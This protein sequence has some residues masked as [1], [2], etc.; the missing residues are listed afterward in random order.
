MSR[1]STLPPGPL[2][3]G[4]A[5]PRGLPLSFS[6][7]ANPPWLAVRTAYNKSSE[8]PAANAGEGASGPGTV[9]LETKLAL[10]RRTP[11]FS[12]LPEDDLRAL[13]AGCRE[14][15]L[16]H[17]DVV[18][19]EGERGSS[20]YVV[21]SGQVVVS[22]QGKRIALGGPGDCFG[23]MALIEGK[24]RSAG[25]SALSEAVVLEIPEDQFHERIA[26]NPQALLALLRTLS[27][28]SRRDLD[29]L[30]R[31]N[32]KLQEYAAEVEKANRE[33]TKIRQQLEEKNR[34]LERLSTLDTLT[35][36]AN[37]R[38]FDEVLRQEWK[39]AARDAAPL[40][41][42]YCDID[43]FKGYNDSY[44]HRAGDEC[45]QRVARVLADAAHRPADL[46]ARYGGEEFVVLLVDTAAEGALILAERMRVSVEQLRIAH[47]SSSI[48]AFLTA[49]FGVAALVPQAAVN[50]EELI[51]R[52]DRALYAAKQ[53][54]R[55]LVVAAPPA[56]AAPGA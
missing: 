20:M 42:I 35:G 21:L 45:L 41:L 43:F 8:S 3:I 2:S 44:G 36:L 29:A 34:L 26:T 25:L 52:A 16:D 27:D 48:G 31:D 51:N 22:K 14:R 46:A 17:G 39:R 49:S 7:G 28:R 30:A 19:E 55:N 56:P 24:V 47:R 37:R 5:G 33:L 50:P 23:E 6:G 11:L 18:F 1:H 38:R 13:V 40:S 32:R 12:P 15:N 53:K 4:T 9:E 54:G 10:L